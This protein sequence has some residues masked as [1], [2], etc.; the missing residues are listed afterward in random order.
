GGVSGPGA[1]S[2][3][4]T[5][6]SDVAAAGRP[7]P[8]E[9]ARERRELAAIDELANRGGKPN[10]SLD[11]RAISPGD[12]G[13]YDLASATHEVPLA[14]KLALLALALL[15]LAGLVLAGRRRFPA[16]ASGRLA[17]LQP[18]LSRVTRLRR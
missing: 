4:G 18:L 14:V 6:A 5:G 9:L 8:A 13:L 16:V 7:T 2:G 1:A 17:G 15:A 12:A 10:L 11:G 3:S